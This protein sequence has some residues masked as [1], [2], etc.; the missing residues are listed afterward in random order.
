MKGKDILKLIQDNPEADLIFWDGEDNWNV[1]TAELD[2]VN[3]SEI[4]LT[5]HTWKRGN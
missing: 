4:V 5:Y 2:A 3:E 1:N